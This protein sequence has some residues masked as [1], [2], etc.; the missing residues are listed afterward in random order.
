MWKVL[1]NGTRG[2]GGH[3][4]TEQMKTR[5]GKGLLPT[6]PRREVE[7]MMQRTWRPYCMHSM[8]ELQCMSKI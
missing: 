2:K 5:K 6:D 8:S 4:G 1:G 7:D 3:G